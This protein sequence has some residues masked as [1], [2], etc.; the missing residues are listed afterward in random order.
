LAK[1]KDFRKRSNLAHHYYKRKGG[2]KF[3]GQN[4]LKLLVAVAILGAV[5]YFVSE[6][7]ID[8][9]HVTKLIFERFNLFVILAILFISESFLG[10]LPPDLFII[11][12]KDQSFPYLMVMILAALSYAGGVISYSYGTQLVKIKPIHDFV[13]IKFKEQFEQ[14]RRFGGLFIFLAAVTPLPFSPVSVVAG[15]VEFPFRK[16]LFVALARF[17]RFFLYALVLFNLV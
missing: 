15:V 12:A 2:Y 5:V 3:L 17:V 4:F 1:Q 8:I 13:H 7:V 11:W 6:Y 14:L 9:E 10:L 16:Y